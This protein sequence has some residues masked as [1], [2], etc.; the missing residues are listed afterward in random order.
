MGYSKNCLKIGIERDRLGLDRSEGCIK[1]LPAGTRPRTRCH[2]YARK[3]RRPDA[4]RNPQ[5]HRRWDRFRTGD[6]CRAGCVSACRRRAARSRHLRPG[7][8]RSRRHGGQLRDAVVAGRPDRARRD[9]GR[10]STA[11]LHPSSRRAFMAGRMPL[12]RLITRYDFADINRAAADATSG[13]A[14]KPVLLMPK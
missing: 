6:V 3:Q 4:C 1:I 7:W 10:Q 5:D 9:P 14:I 8:Q 13:A 12:D 11:G 2:A